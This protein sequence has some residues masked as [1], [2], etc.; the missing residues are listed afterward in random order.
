LK[1]RS[2][3]YAAT[4]VRRLGAGENGSRRESAYETIVSAIIFGDLPPGSATDEKMLARTLGLNLAAVRDALYRLS[5]EGL[6]ER[7]PR[8]GTRIPDLGIRDMQEVFEARVLLEGACAAL[9]AERAAADEIAAMRAAFSG[10]EQAI[11]R[12]DFR[13]LVRMDQTFHRT[14]AA[15]SRNKLVERQVILLHNNALRFW[16]FGLPRINPRALRNDIQAHLHVVD[17]IER[18]DV[19]AA[20]RAMGT[21]LG[22]F[23]EHVRVFL[24][25]TV[26][27][28]EGRSSGKSGTDRRQRKRSQ[29][30]ARAAAG[31]S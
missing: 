9:T 16:Y 27:L 1:T 6:V 5:L 11:E 13:W 3:E 24:T 25:G 8:I 31:L 28:K 14:L 20:R 17:A 18:R 22:R 4:V 10:Y 21:V 26:L 19:A 23:P 2:A 7:Q 30:G 29:K 12:R 15:A